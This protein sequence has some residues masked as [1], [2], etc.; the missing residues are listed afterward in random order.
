MFSKLTC[1]KSTGGQVECKSL[2]SYFD[3]LEILDHIPQNSKCISSGH[4]LNCIKNKMKHIRV[5][6]NPYSL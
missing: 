4:L 5:T 3:S 2:G 1:N 6:Q